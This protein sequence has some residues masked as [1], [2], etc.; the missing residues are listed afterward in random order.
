M[1]TNL[2]SILLV[3]FALCFIAVLDSPAAFVAQET[4]PRAQG[5]AVTNTCPAIVEDA[6]EAL[7]D[8]CGGMGR[9]EACY[10]YRRV[11]STFDFEVAPDF[12]AAPSDRTELASLR[13]I[14]TAPLDV[15]SGQWGIALLNIQANIPDTLPGQAVTFLLLGDA[16]MENQVTAEEAP[17][18]PVAVVTVARANVRSGPGLDQNVLGL[19]D[20]GVELQATAID[21]SGGWLRIDYED[22]SAWI[23]RQVLGPVPDDDLLP[24]ASARPPSPMQSFYF[25]TSTDEPECNEAPDM[26][27]VSSRASITVDLN[28][29]GA[30]ISLGSLI[31]LKQVSETEFTIT[32]VEGQVVTE[33]GSIATTGLT[34]VGRID[35][36]N[37][38]WVEWVEIRPATEEELAAG[39]YA[40]NA[41]EVLDLPE[42]EPPPI[43]GE[44]GGGDEQNEATQPP[45]PVTVDCASMRPTSPLTGLAYGGNTFYWDALA[46]INIDGYRVI[47]TNE[48]TGQVLSANTPAN[49]TNAFLDLTDATIGGGFNFNWYVEA[50][51]GDRVVCASETVRIPRGAPPQTGGSGF[52]A[53][54]G[55]VDGG[56]QIVF[57]GFD[58]GEEVFGTITYFGVVFTEVRSGPDG[59]MF[60]PYQDIESAKF[61]A[62]TSGYVVDFGSFACP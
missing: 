13:E 24:V 18:E 47:V 29:N 19:V 12:F 52:G 32:V 49:R 15:V 54:A 53:S 17:D 4:E 1:K 9:N 39:E 55:C 3:L 34:L 22:S 11:D 37:G 41:Y 8:N 14:R 56:L 30:E 61:E 38:D 60:F 21:E 62:P 48:T 5:P 16:V 59:D 50:L 40:E 44:N 27:A 7:G 42:F 20:A 23:S 10:G 57:N 45:A 28:V 36:E 31:I 35:P 6:L 46:G 58:D 51:R 25:S 26:V 33:T 2:R 43:P